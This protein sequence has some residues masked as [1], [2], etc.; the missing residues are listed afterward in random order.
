MFRAITSVLV[1]TCIT[2]F[3]IYPTCADELKTYIV[4]LS[5]PEGQKFSRPHDREEWYKSLL[6]KSASL[7]HEK[8]SMVFMY[9][10]VITGFAAKLSVEQARVLENMEEV[11]SVNPE[12]VFELQ[13]TRSP[14]FLSLRN[15]SFWRSSNYGKRIIIGLLDTGITPEHPSFSDKGVPPPPAKWKGKCEVAGCTNKLIGIRNFINGSLPI[16][17]DGHG[18]HTRTAAGVQ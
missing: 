12:N 15:H 6:S 18:T 11:V 14:S 10:H 16:D 13:T 2:I 8:P 5:S 7:T 3:S 1:L 17:E 4:H 9:H